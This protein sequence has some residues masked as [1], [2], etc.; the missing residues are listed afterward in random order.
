MTQLAP[1]APTADQSAHQNST[2]TVVLDVEGMMCAGCVSTVEK[3]LAQCEGVV[4]AT[5]NL[6]TEVAAVECRP[7]ADPQVI[8]QTLTAAGYPSQIRPTHGQSA[9]AA[10]TNWLERKQQAQKDQVRQLA[11]RPTATAALSTLA[12]CSI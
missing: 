6:V 8:A 3:K 10:E 2:E 9:L 7:T 4:T 5:V 1:S 12:T 11:D